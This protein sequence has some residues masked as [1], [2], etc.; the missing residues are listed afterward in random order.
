MTFETNV[1]GF[2]K[3]QDLRKCMQNLET[4]QGYISRILQDFAT[5]FCSLL[6]LNALFSYDVI[7]RG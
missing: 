7:L 2:V 5:T 3:T 1:I 4:L 6:I